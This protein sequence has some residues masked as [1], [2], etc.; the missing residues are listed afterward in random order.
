MSPLA[1]GEGGA[2]GPGKG[3]G[4]F[5]ALTFLD[6]SEPAGS[7]TARWAVGG[8]EGNI[9][10]PGDSFHSKCLCR[11]GGGEWNENSGISSHQLHSLGTGP[12]ENGILLT[13]VEVRPAW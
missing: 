11:K 7:L 13:S 5:K 8:Q 4:S 3:C 2:Q 10:S 12:G 9:D 1:D 6:H